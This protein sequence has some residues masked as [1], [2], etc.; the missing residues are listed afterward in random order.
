MVT[1]NKLILFDIDCT[2]L[3]THGAGRAAMKHAMLEV[4]G[5]NDGIDT[6]P[7]GGKTDW[8]SLVDL[9]AP[10][11]YTYADIERIMPEYD[12]VMGRHLAR[13][14][15]DF[16][17]IPCPGAHEVVAALHARPD[18]LLGV[19]TGNCRSS[20]PVKLAAAGFDPALFPVGAF[21]SEAMSRDDLPP[22]ALARAVEHYRQPLAPPQVV[23]VGDTPADV[24]CA[25]ALGAVAVAVRTGF[26]KPGELEA[27][28]PDY[29][30]DDL[31]G[32]EDVLL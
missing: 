7:F 30:I 1:R 6:Y 21:G 32:F 2:L 23:I 12:G 14:A 4:F 5:V 27:T 16:N 25:R 3:W 11:G 19:V 29:L 18:T 31:T 17:I 8:Q 22:L 26:C 9:L 28:A 13:V 15:A 10:H 24:Q 20:S